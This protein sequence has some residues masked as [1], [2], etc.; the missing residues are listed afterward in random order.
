MQ[1]GNLLI[2][3]ILFSC[4]VSS[5]TSLVKRITCCHQAL[6]TENRLKS[7]KPMVFLLS[8]NIFLYIFYFCLELILV[9]IPGGPS[10]KEPAC[11]WRRHKRQRVNP[12]VRKIPGRRKWQPTPAFCLENPLERGAWQATLHRVAKSQILLKH[13]YI[14]KIKWL[15]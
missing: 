3:F 12:W 8:I 9:K 15:K 4:I 10:D 14:V 5:P 13:V 6:Y 1:S 7:W 11:Q 2:S